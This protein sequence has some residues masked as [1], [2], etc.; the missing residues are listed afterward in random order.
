MKVGKLHCRKMRR[1]L[2]K[3]GFF[4]TEKPSSRVAEGL[5][6]IPFIKV[7]SHWVNNLLK[8]HIN[9][10]QLDPIPR[11]MILKINP[12][13]WG[14]MPFFILFHYFFSQI[15]FLITVFKQHTKQ[16]LFST[17]AEARGLISLTSTHLFASHRIHNLW[18][19]DLRVLCK[20]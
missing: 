7:L 11:K 9:I 3:R 2:V 20:N 17:D 10:S 15:F 18:L 13:S 5:V 4:L 1:L 19:Y 14:G 6:C 16:A 8:S 12:S